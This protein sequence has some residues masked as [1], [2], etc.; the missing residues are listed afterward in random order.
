[1]KEKVFLSDNDGTLTTGR[2][3]ITGE[4]AETMLEFADHFKFCL[5]TGSDYQDMVNQMPDGMLMH[6]NVEFWC[7]MGNVLYKGGKEIYNSN[8]TIDLEKFKP[9][10]NEVLEICPI[11]YHTNYPRHFEVSKGCRINLTCHSFG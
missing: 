3:K 7:C 2:R 4:M 9:I 8:H 5:T 6:P 11:K 10:L 1:M